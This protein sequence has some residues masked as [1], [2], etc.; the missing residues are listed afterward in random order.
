LVAGVAIDNLAAELVRR[1]GFT[2]ADAFDLGGVQ[3]VDLWPALASANITSTPSS[4]L[5]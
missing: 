4:H 2:F 5:L 1:P 3:R